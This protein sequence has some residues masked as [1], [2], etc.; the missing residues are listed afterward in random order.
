M[1]RYYGIWRKR[2]MLPLWILQMLCAL[3]FAMVAG[4]LLASA[5]YIE[6]HQ[7]DSAYDGIGYDSYRYTRSQ[8]IEYARTTGGVVLGLGLSTAI[9]D[10]VEIALYAR[11]QLSPVLLLSFACV[12]TL[13][14]GAYSVLSIIGAATG[15][16]SVLDLVLGL[17]LMLTSITQIVLGAV[18]THRKRKGTLVSQGSQKIAGVEGGY[19]M[20]YD[21]AGS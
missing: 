7:R 19:D 10:V 17:V 14:W 5:A 1:Q 8:A 16:I 12:K 13:V 4:L 2:D 3:I 9:L 21:N 15:A 6:S 11:H 20:G 18:N